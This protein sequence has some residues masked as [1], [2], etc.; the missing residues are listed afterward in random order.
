MNAITNP[1]PTAEA[2]SVKKTYPW[3]LPSQKLESMCAVVAW[4]KQTAN[5]PL[6]V[7]ELHIAMYRGKTE[8]RPIAGEPNFNI[9]FGMAVANIVAEK[10]E[11][12]TCKKRYIILLF[13]S[14]VFKKAMMCNICIVYCIFYK[15]A[16]PFWRS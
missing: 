7:R 8:T 10:S 9:S 13:Y 15:A 4:R 12:K 3:K 11:Q 6:Y 5:A 16:L 14:I 1:V 2:P